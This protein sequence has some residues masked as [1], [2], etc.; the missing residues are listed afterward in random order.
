MWEKTSG[1]HKGKLFCK[2]IHVLKE[3]GV[4]FYQYDNEHYVGSKGSYFDIIKLCLLV[5]T[6]GVACICGGL[7]PCDNVIDVN[8]KASVHYTYK[9][10]NNY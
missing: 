9:Y 6:A 7:E 5:V 1:L 3:K 2:I 4:L 10:Y 8:S